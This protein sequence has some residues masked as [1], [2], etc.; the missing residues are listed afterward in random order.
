M[1]PTYKEIVKSMLDDSAEEEVSR[2]PL[3]NNTISR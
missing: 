1:L 3:S 2:I